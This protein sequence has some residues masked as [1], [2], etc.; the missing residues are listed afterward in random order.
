MNKFTRGPGCWMWHGKTN[1]EGYGLIHAGGNVRRYLRAH[2]VVYEH[3]VGPVPDGL[4]LDHLCRVKGCVNP[5]HLEPVTHKENSRRALVRP[6]CKRGHPLDK[7]TGRHRYCSICRREAE[8]RRSTEE[9]NAL[10]RAKYRAKR[11][12]AKL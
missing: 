9:Y 7:Q 5:A 6:C 10:R 12:A 1:A 4:E 8:A 2:R 3:L 11:E